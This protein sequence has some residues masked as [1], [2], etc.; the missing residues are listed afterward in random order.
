MRSLQKQQQQQQQKDRATCVTPTDLPSCFPSRPKASCSSTTSS[1]VETIAAPPSDKLS[2]KNHL[3]WKPQVLLALRGAQVMGLLNRSD[4][5][6]AKT[7]EVEDEN[8]KK[9]IVPNSSDFEGSTTR[10][11]SAQNF[12]P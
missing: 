1:L 11:S 6:P 8:K 2:L 7:L 3:L 5:T 12:I 9:I 4:P 10:K